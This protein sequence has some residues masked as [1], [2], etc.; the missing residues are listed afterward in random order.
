MFE[1]ESAE[2]A[3]KAVAALEAGEGLGDAGR[4]VERDAGAGERLDGR[5]SHERV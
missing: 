4:V 1:E 2:F 5:E 3:V